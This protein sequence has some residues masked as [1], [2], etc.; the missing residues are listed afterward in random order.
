MIHHRYPLR[1]QC[2]SCGGCCVGD[3][4]RGVYMSDSEAERIR[5]LLGVSRSWFRRRYV[6]R[7]GDDEWEA[8]LADDGRCPFLGVRGRCDVYAARP[9]QC[10][11]YPFWP[12]ILASRRCWDREARRCEGIGRGPVLEAAVIELRLR[13]AEGRQ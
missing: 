8:R 3:D 2:T 1:F 13:Q 7:L 10:R 12:E 11:S 5:R 9:D 4:D 6:R